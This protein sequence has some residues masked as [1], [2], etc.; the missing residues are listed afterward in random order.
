MPYVSSIERPAQER[1]REEGR[2]QGREEGL[3][4]GLLEGLALGL[5]LKFG[6][7]G[8]RLLPRMRR[9]EDVARLQSLHKLLKTVAT[10]DELRQA[11][12]V[13]SGQASGTRGKNTCLYVRQC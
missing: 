9:L 11:L 13:N 8:K 3:R 10:L 12:P 2:E 7:A 6:A 4:K 1:G 5:E